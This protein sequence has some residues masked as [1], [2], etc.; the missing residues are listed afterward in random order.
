MFKTLFLVWTLDQSRRRN[1]NVVKCYLEPL[2]R[3]PV[4]F[5]GWIH[6]YF[7]PFPTV[8]GSEIRHPPV[9]VTVVYPIIYRVWDTSQVVVWDFVHQQYVK[10]WFIIQ[11]KQLFII[12]NG[13]SVED[14]PS[15][16]K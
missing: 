7:Q 11:L 3:Q 14:R 8:D 10:I 12:I 13:Q 1:E 15:G 6:Y 4:F 2:T 5:N 9:E 16:C